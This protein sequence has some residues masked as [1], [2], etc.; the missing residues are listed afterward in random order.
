MVSQSAIKKINAM[1]GYEGKKVFS[2]AFSQQPEKKMAAR[3]L[4]YTKPGIKKVYS[5]SYIL[6]AVELKDG[7]TISFHHALRNGDAVMYYIIDA[8]AKK[9]IK[10]LTLSASSLSKVQDCLLPYFERGVI[11]RIDTSGCRSK[12]GNFV[13][14]RKLTQPAIFRTH[15]GRARAIETGELHIDVAFIAAPCCDRFGNINGVQG[16]SACGA[17]GYAMPDAQYADYVVAVTDGLINNILNY[18]SISQTEVDYITEIDSIGDPKGIATGS[19]RISNNPAELMISHY[20]SEV[21]AATEYF[22]NGMVFQ[23]GSG[24]MAIAAAGF[25]RKKM[26]ERHIIA[27][28]GVGGVSEFHVKMLHEGLIN[29]FYDPQDFDLTAIDSLRN[30]SNHMEISASAYANPFSA[31]PYVNLLDFTVLSATEM[32]IHFNVNVLTDSYGKLIGAAGGHP[33][34]AAGAK[35]TVITMPLLR[36]RLPMLLDHVVTIV[37][38][39]ETV[40]VLVTEYGIAVNPRRQ[41]ILT[42]LKGKGLPIK[43]IEELK[44]IADSLTGRMTAVEFSDTIAGIVEYRDGSVID[45]IHEI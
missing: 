18:V 5:L 21:I 16:S 20:A 32:D 38:P 12:L 31:S 30:N 23:F 25:I 37:T 3:P 34:S 10:N 27:D 40:D 45:I 33:D 9:G 43:S 24:G 8:I 44:Y 19:I 22:R 28:A 41:D 13:Q 17:L 36:G 7:M 6:D 26:L 4:K 29:A 11:T 15:G 1:P 35:M 42:C 14:Q 39:G 2:G